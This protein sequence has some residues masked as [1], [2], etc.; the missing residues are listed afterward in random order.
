MIPN[1]IVLGL[2]IY[3]MYAG[4]ANLITGLLLIYVARNC[5]S[6]LTAFR[7]SP[8]MAI[9]NGQFSFRFAR[10]S[11][12]CPAADV[13]DLH[14]EEKVVHLTLFD[15]SRVEPDTARQ[16]MGAFDRTTGC[17]IGLPAGIYNLDQVNQLRKALGE[18]E[19]AGPAAAERPHGFDVEGPWPLVTASLIAACVV[20]C[21]AQAFRDR[22]LSLWGGN[23]VLLIAGRQFRACGTLAGQWWRLVTHLFLHIGLLH[24]LVNMW[25]LWIVGQ[26]LERLTGHTAMAIVYLFAGIAG[27]MASLA[28]HPQVVSAGASGAIFG[29]IGALFGL[30]LHAR[31]VVPP[32]QL[33]PLRNWVIAIVIFNVFF[34]LS[35][36]GIDNAAQLAGPLPDCWPA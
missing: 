19:Q 16:Q 25:S 33:Q 32:A 11:F 31:D 34:G 22:S 28:F 5:F 21:L 23:V 36:P 30:L 17:H 29:L 2:L 6:M 18:P 27:G 8:R 24:L 14:W 9:H 4:G 13:A 1:F 20:V 3:E 26:L 12:V 35:V 7:Q 15:T 10:L